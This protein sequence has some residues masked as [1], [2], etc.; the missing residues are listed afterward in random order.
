MSGLMS[1]NIWS[2]VAAITVSG[3]IADANGLAFSLQQAER[4]TGSRA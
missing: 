2:E 3:T 4:G 1:R